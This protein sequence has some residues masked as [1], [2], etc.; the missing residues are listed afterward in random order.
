MLT[1]L[2]IVGAM[3]LQTAA[4]EPTLTVERGTAAVVTAGEEFAVVLRL[5]VGTEHVA[6]RIRALPPEL[7]NLRL[8]ALESAVNQPVPGEVRQYVFTYR[9]AGVEAGAA[10]AEGFQVEMVSPAEGALPLILNAAGFSLQVSEPFNWRGAWPW[11]AAVGIGLA[12]IAVAAWRAVTASREK[13]APSEEEERRAA[14]IEALLRHKLR[15]EWK[16]VVNAAFDAL[17]REAMALQP[18]GMV[19]RRP[20]EEEINELARRWPEFPALW[21]LG[22]EVRYGGYEP[23]KREAVYVI[24]QMKR[25]VQSS[26]FMDRGQPSEEKR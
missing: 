21:R 25:M 9:L 4:A 16:G 19:A 22:E 18:R 12:A 6:D 10:N 20:G 2:Q 5:N 3:L 17:Q 14:L 11:L 8:I 24:K 23:S 1:F 26:W 13:P 7:E 15:R